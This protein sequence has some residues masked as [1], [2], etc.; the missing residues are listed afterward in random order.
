VIICRIT[1]LDSGLYSPRRKLDPGQN[2]VSRVMTVG[3]IAKCNCQINSVKSFHR[4]LS[5]TL[6]FL[7]AKSKRRKMES[8]E[9]S[10]RSLISCCVMD[11]TA[12]PCCAAEM[13]PQYLCRTSV[14]RFWKFVQNPTVSRT[15]FQSALFFFK[16][17]SPSETSLLSIISGVLT[18]QKFTPSHPSSLRKNS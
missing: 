10:L 16:I 14:V 5:H 13:L 1:L 12:L 6:Y 15:S 9:S 11:A 4:Q 2:V 17:L 3:R 18:I 8:E 7:P